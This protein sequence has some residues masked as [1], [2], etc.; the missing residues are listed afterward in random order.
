MENLSAQDISSSVQDNLATLVVAVHGDPVAS[1][2]FLARTLKELKSVSDSP[3]GDAVDFVFVFDGALWTTLPIVQSL[4][5]SLP[6]ARTIFTN[7]PCCLPAE[8]FN[9]A[10]NVAFGRYVAF[11]R[12]T[13]AFDADTLNAL[14]AGL[15]TEETS[16]EIRTLLDDTQLAHFG[17]PFTTD[18][19]VVHAWLLCSDFV[20]PS[21]TLMPTALVKSVGGFDPS[22]ILQQ[23]AEWALLVRLTGTAAVRVVGRCKSSAQAKTDL[24]SQYSR[25]YPASADIRRRY[26]AKQPSLSQRSKTT[27]GDEELVLRDLPEGN[28]PQTVEGWDGGCGI[29]YATLRSWS[30]LDFEGERFR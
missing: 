15:S 12:P 23:S 6:K 10:L 26:I 16:H 20:S 13:M 7:E 22:P 29:D 18:G 4:K 25:P 30:M 11:S 8:L 24:M 2:T 1:E 27:S 19:D 21:K 3:L 9:R 5:H 17:L 14:F 28:V